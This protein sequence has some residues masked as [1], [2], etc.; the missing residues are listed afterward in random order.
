MKKT[1]EETARSRERIVTSASRRFREGGFAGVSVKDLMGEAGLTHG[2]F[3]AHFP[4]KDALIGA[5]CADAFRETTNRLV[6][7]A[8]ATPDETL[9]QFLDNYLSRPHLETP[10]R[11]CA[12]A[13][14]ASEAAREPGEV[15]AAFSDGIATMIDRLAELVPG[16]D[17]SARRERAITVFA[18][19]VGTLVLARA[20]ESGDLQDAILAAARR[21]LLP[22][23]P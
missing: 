13:A 9:T 23:A 6:P 17:P 20:V 21:H 2:A 18:E 16:D 8:G 22:P 7:R 15:K 10:A 19:A 11:G 12:I 14:L 3:Y 5:A 4:S 1:K